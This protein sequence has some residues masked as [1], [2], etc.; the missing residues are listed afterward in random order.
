MSD[1]HKQDIEGCNYIMNVVSSYFPEVEW[2][3]TEG[4]YDRYDMDWTMSTTGGKIIECKAEGKDRRKNKYGE[5]INIDTYP[6][7]FLNSAKFRYMVNHFKNPYALMGYS[8]GV[9]IYNLKK[10]PYEEIID[11]IVEASLAFGN[12]SYEWKT[13]VKINDWTKWKYVWNP[14]RKKKNWE[15]NVEL[16]IPPK[17]EK[18]KGVTVLKNVKQS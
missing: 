2:T 18:I 12:K 4:E 16:P 1:C 13:E 11:D 15:L 9:V 7:A 3:H 6:T 17:D 10:F 14:A 8:D 5:D